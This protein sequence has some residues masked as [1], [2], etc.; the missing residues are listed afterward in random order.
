MVVETLKNFQLSCVC[1]ECHSGKENVFL[2]SY[3]NPVI[4]KAQSKVIEPPQLELFGNPQKG[5]SVLSFKK[6]KNFNSG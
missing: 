3:H 1:W 5:C 6:S 2:F 4:V